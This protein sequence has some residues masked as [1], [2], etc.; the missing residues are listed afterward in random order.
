MKRDNVNYLLVGTFVL[1]AFFSLLVLLYRITGRDTDTEPYFVSYENITGVAVGTPVTY[2]GY[3]VGRVEQ[4]T[5]NRDNART[6][7]RLRLA[8]R[9]GWAIPSDSVARIVSPGLLSE[10]IIDIAEGSNRDMLEPGQALRGQEQVSM[11]SLLNSMAYELKDLSDTRIKP[12]LEN[13]NRRV[14]SIG[15]ELGESIPRLTARAD[16][17]LERLGAAAAGL[18]ALFSQDNQDRVSDVL[19]NSQR[20]S[21]NMAELSERFGD[22]R[23][24]LDRLLASSNEIV[25]ENRGDLREAVLALRRSME[26]IS[27][28]VDSIVY[29]LESSSRN[30]NEF[31]RQIRQNPGLLLGTQPPRDDQGRRR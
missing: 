31:S 20:M 19:E 21:R 3:Q 28:N 2:G 12:L 1:V 7:Y 22:M 18:Q 30:M 23:G 10:N 13:L 15:G 17:L 4:I 24:E 9:E 27:G 6:E 26:V 25:A 5:P 16:A 8:I 11:M 14:E 29:H